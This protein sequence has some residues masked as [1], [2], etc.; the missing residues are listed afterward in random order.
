MNVA[1]SEER[2]A[3]H[4][5]VKELIETASQTTQREANVESE[6]SHSFTGAG[7]M[8]LFQGYYDDDTTETVNDQEVERY[9]VSK[10]TVV[11]K[12]FH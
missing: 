1:S 6:T 12:K 4:L 2:N 11:I 9:I 7:T 3:I 5:H 8:S 10:I